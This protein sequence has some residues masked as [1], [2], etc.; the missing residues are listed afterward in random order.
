MDAWAFNLSTLH[1]TQVWSHTQSA[2]DTSARSSFL[3][4]T[5]FYRPLHPFPMTAYTWFYLLNTLIL[6][7]NSNTHGDV[8]N[9]HTH[10]N[11]AERSVYQGGRHQC[12][13]YRK[14]AGGTNRSPFPVSIIAAHRSSR[15]V[16]H[17]IS[18]VIPQHT[19][20]SA[21]PSSAFSMHH[22]SSPW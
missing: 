17:T 13:H 11:T 4:T 18:T 19:L 6:H 3:I 15:D 20:S 21:S 22:T 1:C 7:I 8:H 10:T 9:T 16:M 12:Y 5:I 2:H 14:Q